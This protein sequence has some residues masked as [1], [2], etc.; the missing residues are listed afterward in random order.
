MSVTLNI[1]KSKVAILELSRPEKHNAF[2]AEIIAEL[3]KT[4]EYANE[5]DI[6]ALVLKTQGKHFSAGADL[7]WMK[8]MADN[9]YEENVADSL[10]LAKLMQVLATSPHP[11]LCLVQGAAFGGALGLIACCDIAVATPNAKFCLSEVKLGLIPAVISPYVIKAIGERQ[12]R[13]YF[14]TAE[15]FQAEKALDLGLIH[16]ISDNLEQSEEYFIEQLL[17]NGP[18]AVKS[19]KSLIDEVSDKAIDEQLITHTAKRIAEIRVSDEGQE[20]LS[21][22]FDKRAPNWQPTASE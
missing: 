13:R 10:E 12:A 21:A 14:L 2:N 6:R 16:Q 19:A 1:T 22:F 15:V 9:N 7:A 4:I 11:T 17:N 20:G 18:T 3:I 5:L 8:S